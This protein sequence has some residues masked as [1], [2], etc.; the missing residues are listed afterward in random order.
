MGKI[1][2]ADRKV[3]SSIYE[4]LSSKEYEVQDLLGR[5]YLWL[6][7]NGFHE[8]VAKRQAI[9]MKKYHQYA[10][11]DGKVS[12]LL[13]DSVNKMRQCFAEDEKYDSVLAE[14]TGKTRVATAKKYYIEFIKEYYPE[15]NTETISTNYTSE[16]MLKNYY[17][18]LK[19]DGFQE[20]I[21][22]QHMEIMQRYHQYSVEV[23]TESPLFICNI[24]QIRERFKTDKEYESLLITDLDISRTR[25]VS[26]KKYFITFMEEC[27]KE[28]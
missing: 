25:I 1:I 13:L 27:C 4:G 16:Q 23:G 20:R 11:K 2:E 14:G 24:E 3:F 5:Y 12:P 9:V 28:K 10:I 7:K 8:M 26:A 17:E 6:V 21:A 19:A 18:W 22:K 15:R